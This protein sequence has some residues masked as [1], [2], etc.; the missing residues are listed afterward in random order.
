MSM[1]TVP[2]FPHM[3]Q[4][5]VLYDINNNSFVFFRC[6]RLYDRADRFRDAPLFADDFS[7]IPLCDM[8]LKYSCPSLLFLIDRNFFRMVNK[9]FCDYFN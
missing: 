4:L 5:T 6:R 7:H 3:C 8:Q 2:L 9:C 1:K